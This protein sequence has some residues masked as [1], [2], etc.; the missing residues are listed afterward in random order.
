MSWLLSLLHFQLY[1]LAQRETCSE[2]LLVTASRTFPCSEVA[3]EHCRQLSHNQPTQTHANNCS[4]SNSMK[5]HTID[6]PCWSLQYPNGS[7]ILLYS[8]L[9]CSRDYIHNMLF[10]HT[11]S[12]GAHQTSS[13]T[14]HLNLLSTQHTAIA[15][16]A[17]KECPCIP[18]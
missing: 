9:T 5:D 10:G 17:P 7:K 3:R 15:V 1:E 12:M 11:S 4:I 18:K 2:S 13:A 6:E 16:A 14:Q 8:V